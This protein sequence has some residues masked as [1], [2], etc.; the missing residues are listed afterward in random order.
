MIVLE[1]APVLHA[2]VNEHPPVQPSSSETEPD[3][4]SVSP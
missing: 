3:T 1:V 4:L 2:Y